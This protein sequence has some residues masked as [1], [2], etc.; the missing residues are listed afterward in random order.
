MLQVDR[1]HPLVPMLFLSSQ[2]NNASGVWADYLGT[3]LPQHVV[4]ASA[5]GLDEVQ[6]EAI[7][8]SEAR[9]L[10]REH[11]AVFDGMVTLVGAAFPELL[12]EPALRWAASMVVSRSFQIA[13]PRTLPGDEGHQAEEGVEGE[14][15][16]PRGIAKRR[17]ML[18]FADFFNHA[19]G[20]GSAVWYDANADAFKLKTLRSWRA[21]EEVFIDYGDLSPQELLAQHGI[22]S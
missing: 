11:R 14:G 19:P 15:G 2:R 17:V 7:A 6:I 8:D 1:N 22:G 10:V 13:L 12:D 20:S 21:G 3:Q 4:A 5:L 16:G 9:A 18:P